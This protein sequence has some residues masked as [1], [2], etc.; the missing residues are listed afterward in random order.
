MVQDILFYCCCLMT[1]SF[2]IYL[3]YALLA[4]SDD[5]DMVVVVLT[6]IYDYYIFDLV[7]ILSCASTCKR[8]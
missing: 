7:S 4:A 6:I 3:G 8:N 2:N 5:V 1:M